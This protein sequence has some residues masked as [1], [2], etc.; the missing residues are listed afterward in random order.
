QAP[1]VV[2]AS[3]RCVGRG[4]AVSVPS[5]RN[6]AIYTL[7]RFAPS[8]LM[9]RLAARGREVPGAVPGASAGRNGAVRAVPREAMRKG[10]YDASHLEDGSGPIGS[11]PRSRTGVLLQWCPDLL[12]GETAETTGDRR[13]SP[14]PARLSA[15]PSRRPC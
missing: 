3:L 13:R 10:E 4:R 6:R 1:R 14:P 5:R 2:A 9:S 7:S 8:S 15:R 12:E 11:R